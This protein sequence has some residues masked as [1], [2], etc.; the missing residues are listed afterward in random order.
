VYASYIATLEEAFAVVG[1]SA[2]RTDALWLMSLLEGT[3]IFLG[4]GRRWEG[5]AE[6]VRTRVPEIIDDRYGENL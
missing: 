2:P 1:S 4:V 3:T 6:A 5:D